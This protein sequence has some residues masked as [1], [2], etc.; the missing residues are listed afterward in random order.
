MEKHQELLEQIKAILQGHKEGDNS[1]W[2]LEQIE[3]IVKKHS[4][5]YYV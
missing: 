3:D 4:R 1:R 2:C 5:Y